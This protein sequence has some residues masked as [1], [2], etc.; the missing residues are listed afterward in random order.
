M[1]EGGDE[2]EGVMRQGVRQGPQPEQLADA[3]WDINKTLGAATER[4]PFD[5]AKVRAEIAK[6]EEIAKEISDRNAGPLEKAAVSEALITLHYADGNG[7]D[8]PE[9]RKLVQSNPVQ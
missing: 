2:S 5:L 7:I 6:A 9:L 1:I 3:L 8:A 4:A